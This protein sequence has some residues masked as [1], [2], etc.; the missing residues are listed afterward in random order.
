MKNIIIGRI[1][2]KARSTESKYIFVQTEIIFNTPH[3]LTKNLATSLPFSQPAAPLYMERE[4]RTKLKDIY[5]LDL[6][7]TAPANPTNQPT[8]HHPA[9]PLKS[10]LVSKSVNSS[11]RQSQSKSYKRKRRKNSSSIDRVDVW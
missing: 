7:S 10:Q 1:P 9:I 11:Q 4:E 2:K 3:N 8:I 5:F 6:F